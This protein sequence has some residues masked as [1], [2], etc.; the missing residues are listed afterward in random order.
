MLL[1]SQMLWWGMDETL[2]E[3]FTHHPLAGDF[4]GN[5]MELFW[6]VIDGH[7]YGQNQTP[8][9]IGLYGGRYTIEFHPG[10]FA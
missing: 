5:P 1:R 3:L 9:S 8:R 7:K 4:E 6:G 10:E 2:A